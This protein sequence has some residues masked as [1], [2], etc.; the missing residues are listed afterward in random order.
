MALLTAAQRDEV[1]RALMRFW[2]HTSETTSFNNVDLRT[3]VDDTDVWIDAREGNTAPNT[4]GYNGS[5]SSNSFKIG[6]SGSQKSDC[7]IFTAARRRSVD[8]L[9]LLWAE[10]G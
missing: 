6:A 7:F 3:A 9:K 5:L 8:I 1:W 4:V 2:S 10:I